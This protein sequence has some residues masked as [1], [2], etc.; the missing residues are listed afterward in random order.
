MHGF[1][2]QLGGCFEMPF[3]GRF[4]C[5]KVAGLLCTS[6]AYLMQIH[7]RGG[8]RLFFKLRTRRL[9]NCLIDADTP[10]LAPYI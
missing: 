7:T 10:H 6:V 4:K 8:C 5:R 2:M 1:L 3:A 9:R